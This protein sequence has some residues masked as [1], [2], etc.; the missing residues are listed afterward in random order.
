LIDLVLSDTLGLSCL[1]I[2]AGNC[3]SGPNFEGFGVN[4][5]QISVFLFITQK[6][7]PCTILHLLSHYASK[8]D[9]GWWNLYESCS[10]PS[11]S[12]DAEMVQ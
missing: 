1:S 7:H 6:V 3:Y 4:K 8:S 2:L 5:G 11:C 12:V 10:R 9:Y